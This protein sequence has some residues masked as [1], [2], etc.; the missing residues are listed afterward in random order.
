MRKKNIEYTNRK[1]QSTYQIQLMKLL[2]KLVKLLPKRVRKKR[3]KNCDFE[4]EQCLNQILYLLGKLRVFKITKKK[5]A[6]S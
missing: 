4:L 6:K 1:A 5:I 3:S 2:L